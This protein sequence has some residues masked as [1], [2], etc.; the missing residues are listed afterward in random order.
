MSCPT[1]S[2]RSSGLH[3]TAATHAGLGAL[4]LAVPV[5]D[6][7]G[8]LALATGVLAAKPTDALRTA[9]AAFVA[10]PLSRIG[11][12]ERDALLD[13]AAAAHQAGLADLAAA[14]FAR[15]QSAAIG[16]EVR[17]VIGAI[18]SA[19]ARVGALATAHAA[20]LRMPRAQRVYEIR[21]LLLGCVERDEF[22]AL[23][24]LLSEIPN[25]SLNDRGN[26]SMAMIAAAAR[27]RLPGIGE[28]H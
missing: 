19:A 21:P 1:P 4:A 8:R 26:L 10:G 5:T 9:A 3:W 12:H 28:P 11:T 24:H 17:W 15:V 6:D 14:A 16:R 18:V 27:A 7:L 13:L 20:L 2:R 23:I 25:E 22:A